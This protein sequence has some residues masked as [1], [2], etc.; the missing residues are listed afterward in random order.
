MIGFPVFRI[1]VF[2]VRA[3]SRSG[4]AKPR[5]AIPGFVSQDYFPLNDFSYV[6]RSPQNIFALIC[7]DELNHELAQGKY[8]WLL[9]LLSSLNLSNSQGVGI[10]EQGVVK[11]FRESL[12]SLKFPPSHLFSVPSFV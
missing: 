7:V 2:S 4:R 10:Q 11:T 9:Y 3:F 1:W 5:T 8:C 6:F 12:R